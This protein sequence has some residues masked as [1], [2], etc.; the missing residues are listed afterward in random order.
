MNFGEKL[1]QLRTERGIY[2][3]DL[4]R[5]LAV[6]I[7]TVSNYENGIHAPDLTTLCKIAEYFKVSVDYLLDLTQNA[8]PIDNLNIKLSED[9]TVGSALNI[10]LELSQSSRRKLARYLSMIKIC[11][12]ATLKDQTI[13]RQKQVI[14]RQKSLIDRQRQAID[15]QKQAIE[16]QKQTVD[17]QKREIEQQKQAADRREQE[18]EQQKRAADRREWEIEQQKRAVDRQKQEIEQQKQAADRRERAIELQAQEISRLKEL[19]EMQNTGFA[20]KVFSEV[21]D[22]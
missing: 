1:F 12:E 9:C 16:R 20:P 3:K 5:Y 19:L 15:Q 21:T 11:E 2:Q 14:K 7:G 22:I 13:G 10:I 8:M 17:R 18:I 4:A 6:S